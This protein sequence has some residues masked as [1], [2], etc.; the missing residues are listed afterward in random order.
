M[1]RIT[2]PIRKKLMGDLT[3]LHNKE[4]ENLYPSL[5]SNRMVKAKEYRYRPRVAQRVPGS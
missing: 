1:R 4:F 5:N 2:E 3:E